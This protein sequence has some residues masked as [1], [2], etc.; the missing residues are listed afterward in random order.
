MEFTDDIREYSKPL[1]KPNW[2]TLHKFTHS[3]FNIQL[4]ALQISNM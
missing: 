3:E 4:S 2:K 1:T